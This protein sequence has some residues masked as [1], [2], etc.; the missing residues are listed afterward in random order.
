MPDSLPQR[1]TKVV[2]P[3]RREAKPPGPCAMVIFGA[4]GD[5]TKRLLVPALYNLSR[6]GLL[7][8]HFAIVG[9]DAVDQD[10]AAWSKSLRDMLQ[11]FVGNAAS[12]SRIDA[13]DDTAWQRLTDAMSY[14]KGDFNDP[15]LFEKLHAHLH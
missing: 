4:G 1:T 11:S 15:G 8:E 10:A 9:V 14:L 2:A 7:P 13:V 12:E 5:L 3:P 6:T